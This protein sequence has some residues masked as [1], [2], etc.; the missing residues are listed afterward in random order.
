VLE[1][2]EFAPVPPL[3]PA[4]D[5][6]WTL[7]GDRADLRD[8]A[9]PILPDGRPELVVHFGDAF[10][11]IDLDGRIQRQPAVLFAG[12]LQSRLIL[13][14]TGDIAVLGV[15]F[16]SF[17]AAALFR[18]PQREVAGLT[19][20]VDALARALSRDLVRVRDGI[21][22]PA[23]ASPH[24]QHVLLRHLD[25]AR[26]DPRVRHAA[27]ALTREERPLAVDA[28]AA[29]VGLTRRHLERKF[30]T[31]VGIGPKR[32][33]RIARFSRAV[34]ALEAADENESHSATAFT[35]GYADQ[36]HFIREF[37][38]LAGCPPG[39]HLLKRGELTGFFTAGPERM[40]HSFN[41]RRSRG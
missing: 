38:D 6:L 37:R 11:R 29:S 7:T 5:C 31:D 23:D 33:A 14:P 20:G 13:R 25:L 2:R 32:L 34:Q 35:C 15:R 36:A 19:L 8:A 21:R 24:V 16:H 17:G 39:E 4:V 40:S 12:Q 28:A 10:E 9:Q 30:L 3:A 18:T 27:R 22:S 1:Y 41:P 26:I